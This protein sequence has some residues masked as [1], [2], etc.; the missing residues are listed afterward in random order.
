MPKTSSTSSSSAPTETK[1]PAHV[2]V[3]NHTG[4][5][6]EVV[7]MNRPAGK[8]GQGAGFRMIKFLPG[9]ND[10]ASE[11]LKGCQAH[12]LWH[13]HATRQEHRHLGGK[14]YKAVELEVG[15][16]DKDFE[17]DSREL[18]ERMRLAHEA[19]RK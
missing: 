8:P 13:I 17:T 16:Y 4:H 6:I 7:L 18:E 14:R 2:P 12:P 19:N 9:N 11:D 1:A 5:M 3:F 10:I 15:L